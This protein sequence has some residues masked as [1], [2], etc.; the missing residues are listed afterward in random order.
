[1]SPRFGRLSSQWRGA[2]KLSS[3]KNEAG[4]AASFLPDHWSFAVT[5]SLDVDARLGPIPDA[6]V[7]G[8]HDPFCG[9]GLTQEEAAPVSDAL[10]AQATHPG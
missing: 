2:L 9:N 7:D 3:S 1:M 4:D 5:S 8:L 10:E 6:R